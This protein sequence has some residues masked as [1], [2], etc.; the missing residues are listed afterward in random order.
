MTN[1]DLAKVI[2]GDIEDISY[3]EDKYPERLN[4]NMV[5]R[6]AP[7]P[8]G[9]I[10]TG[11]LF[12][13]L[14]AYHMAKQENG[15]FYIRLED[16]DTK[17]EINDSKFL[18]LSQL[19]EFGIVPDEGFLGTTQ[20]GDYGP[21]VQSE[22]KHI[23]DIVINDLVK[24]GLAYPC[25]CNQEELSNLRLEQTNNKERTGYYKDYAKCRNISIE[26]AINRI[27][28][29]EE[30]IIRF[31]SYGNFDEKIRVID[32]IRG[33]LD[34]SCNDQ[35]IVIRKK[36]GLPTYHFAHM[37]D[38]HFMH[39]TCVIRG[40]EWLPSL[41]IH[42]ELF[43]AM[44]YKAPMYAHLPVIMKLDNGKRRKLSKRLDHEASVSFFIEAGYPKE[45]ILEYLYTL[46]NSNYEIERLKLKSYSDFKMSFDKMS[47]DGALFDMEKIGSI[48]KEILGN[49]TKE[50]IA[51]RAYQWALKYDSKLFDFINKDYEYFVSIMNLERDKENKR[52]DYTNY[53]DIYSAINYF[54]DDVY[55]TLAIEF[56][57]M[58]NDDIFD[59]YLNSL[60]CDDEIKWLE[61]MK[62]QA[63][64]LGYCTN[65]KEY[66]ANKEAYK[67]NFGDFMGIVRIMA[68][69]KKVSQNLYYVGN[70]ISKERLRKRI[71]LLNK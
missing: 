3:L 17:R 10:H 6:F 12:A 46:S 63:G 42:L 71:L 28:N 61:Y 45:A 70:I 57:D 48:S 21:Y 47:L 39:T 53:G 32:M 52:K 19:K 55:K 25:F 36:D 38:D 4:K 30:Y 59:C 66:K 15:I 62:I 26:D 29:K 68:T 16:T 64:L 50:E 8:T 65:N 40:E 18:L 23:Y 2:F 60:D 49:M 56:K 37:V 14:I 5:T 31:K 9:F 58:F 20:V 11:S 1:E 27:N 69:G 51:N 54:D 13:S 67:G 22:R 24:R 34:L 41:P 44:G 33:E 7:S 43:N 35:D